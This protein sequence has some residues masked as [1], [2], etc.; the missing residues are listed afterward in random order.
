VDGDGQLTVQLPE[1]NDQGAYD[2]AF[3]GDQVTFYVS[4]GNLY[5]Q[6]NGGSAELFA[7][8]I[9]AATFTVAA[10]MVT[11]SCTGQ[12]ESGQKTMQTEFSQKVLLRNYVAE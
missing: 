12:G 4:G 11:L 7:R 1:V 2:R 10:G 6:V 3:D 8:G 9:T 5:S